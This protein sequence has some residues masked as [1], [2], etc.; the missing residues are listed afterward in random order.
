M[1]NRHDHFSKMCSRQVRLSDHT[2]YGVG[3]YADYFSM[4]ETVE[5]LVT[6]LDVCN[7]IGMNYFVFGMGTNILF[8]D[9]PKRDTLFIS[10]K[11]LAEFKVDDS[12]WFVSA[13]LP[14]S[15]LSLAG[16]IA[17]TPDFQ[18]TYLLPGCVGAGIYMNAKYHDD[19]IGEKIRRVHYIDLSEQ[20]VSLQTIV[21]EDCQFAY[22]QSIFQHKPWIIVGAE[23]AIPENAAP[24]AGGL[25]DTLSRYRLL[26]GSSL[27]SFYSFFSNEVKQVGNGHV[28][29]YLLGVEQ[30]RTDKRHFKYRSCGSFFKNNCSVGASIGAL[31]D[32]LNLKGAARGGALISPYH[33][34][35]ILNHRRATASDILYLKDTVTDAI[36]LHYG[37]IPEPE[38]VIVAGG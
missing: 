4:P 1:Y 5:Q 37:F 30:Y 36:Y 38:V 19:Q 11:N 23:I 18:F 8:P 14:L 35:M 6:L 25:T 32:K 7:T 16:L 28:P 12:H 34:N 3:G 22:K 21:A 33:G 17:G 20:T 29:D 10:L 24:T 15:M 13:G 2:S 27:S 31:V 26:N 9:Q